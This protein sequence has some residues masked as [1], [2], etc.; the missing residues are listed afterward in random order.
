LASARSTVNPSHVESTASPS[1]A[2]GETDSALGAD[3]TASDPEIE[4][5]AVAERAGIMR[6]FAGAIEAARKRL[7]RRK[8]MGAVAALKQMRKAALAL[9]KRRASEQRAGRKKLIA[10]ARRSITGRR[11]QRPG[12]H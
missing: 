6:E 3:L 10:V 7:P 12:L 8:A 4:E 11:D 1:E 9:V 2:T 5:S